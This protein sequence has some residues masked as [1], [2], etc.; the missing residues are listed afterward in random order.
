MNFVAIFF[1]MIPFLL[2]L[3]LIPI[4]IGVY[5]YRDAKRRQMNA[6]AWTAIA[7][8][9]PTFIGLIIYLLV[10]RNKYDDNHLRSVSA[11]RAS[12]N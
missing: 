12:G 3:L 1:V 6:V 7:V 2:L 8:L 4:L 9:A 11:V 10:R 5:V